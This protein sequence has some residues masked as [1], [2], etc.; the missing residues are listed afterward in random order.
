MV[1]Y[2]SVEHKLQP[3]A[4]MLEIGILSHFT[5]STKIH[6]RRYSIITVVYC[7]WGITKGK[8]PHFKMP[9]EFSISVSL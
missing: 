6:T 4:G 7:Y 5:D 3:K 8:M 9:H 1:A 2:L